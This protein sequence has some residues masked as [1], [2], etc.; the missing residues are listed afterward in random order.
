MASRIKLRYRVSYREM[1][2]FW[3]LFWFFPPLSIDVLGGSWMLADYLYK[4]MQILVSTGA[5]LSYLVNRK[6]LASD[7]VIFLLLHFLLIIVA[8]VF[9]KSISIVLLGQMYAAIGFTLLC[10]ECYRKSKKNFL[11][12][13]LSV[14]AVLAI[15]GMLSAYI[16]PNGFTNESSKYRAVYFL[17]TKNNSFPFYFCYL[18]FL[19]VQSM[20]ENRAPDSKIMWMIIVMIGSSLIFQSVNTLLCLL[21]ILAVYVVATRFTQVLASMNMRL[22]LIIVTSVIV[23]VYLGSQTS[24][25]SVFLNSLGR[26]TTFSGRDML[27]KQAM[28]YFAAKPIFGAGSVLSY[29][30]Y[31]GIEAGHAH[32]Q[33]LDRLARYGILPAIMLVCL[34]VKTYTKVPK[35]HNIKKANLLSILLLIYMIHMSFDSYNLNFFIICIFIV[36]CIFDEDNKFRVIKR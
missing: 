19:F 20:E 26:S 22:I 3:A 17:G 7:Y 28:A 23:L 6:R 13:A 29:T 30:A 4:G 35:C 12:A 31:S 14:F 9:N 5:Y 32:S 34:I 18:F 8:C 33:F 10:A 27:W 15:F 25:F 21:L 16:F 36:N 24:I 1:L 11:N 2:Y